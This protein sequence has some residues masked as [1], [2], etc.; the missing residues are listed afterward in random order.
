MTTQVQPKDKTV[1]ANGIKIRYLDWGDPSNPKMVL[2]HGLRG[3]A[4]AW[5]DFSE[6]MSK[7]YNVLALDQRGRGGSDWAP[8][9]DYTT[10]AY[11][12]DLAAFCEVLNLDSFILVGH[13]MGGRNGAAFATRYPERVGKLVMVDVGPVSD[14]R[15][16]TRIRDE[17]LAV[18]DEFDSFEALYEYMSNENTFASERVLRRRL[19]YASTDL[20]NG[21]RGW[22]Y[23]IKTIRE[24]M[25]VGAPPPDDP[26]ALVRD[27]KCPT[28]IVRGTE[29]DLLTPEVAKQM[30][31][32]IADA[33]VVEV[34][35]AQ[36]MVFEDNPE[37]FL[38]AVQGWLK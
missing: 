4:H 2:L 34:E 10:D 1:S 13:S 3:H 6:P 20:P 37:G 35:K 22:Q 15:G 14:P 12:A 11:V 27:I 29:T 21:K 32:T 36:H 31:D 19:Q 8:D 7:D 30:V 25:R 16:A 9:K 33:T 17:V 18:A 23:D 28:L 5:N 26:W 38:A 24:N